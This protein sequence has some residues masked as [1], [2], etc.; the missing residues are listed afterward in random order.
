MASLSIGTISS[1]HIRIL[2]WNPLLIA[3]ITCDH[4]THFSALCYSLVLLYGTE[5]TALIT[6]P[7]IPTFIR[8]A[9]LTYVCARARTGCQRC[10]TLAKVEGGLANAEA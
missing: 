6:T 7:L 1:I 3:L 5:S 9:I 10:K 4:M 2:S 8:C